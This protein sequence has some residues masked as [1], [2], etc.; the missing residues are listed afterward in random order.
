LACVGRNQHFEDDYMEQE[1][2]KLEK[3]RSTA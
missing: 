2:N 3:H 1:L